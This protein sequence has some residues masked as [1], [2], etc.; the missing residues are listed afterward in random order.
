VPATC[1]YGSGSSAMTWRSFWR[2]CSRIGGHLP[3]EDHLG[4][5]SVI[6]GPPVPSS[7]GAHS[8][9]VGPQHCDN[10]PSRRRPGAATPAPVAATG[11]AVDQSAERSRAIQKTHGGPGPRRPLGRDVD[12]RV[13]GGAARAVTSDLGN[14]EAGHTLQVRARASP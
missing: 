2:A 12:G 7:P 6:S 4:T 14:F 5:H 10:P 1:P 3:G 11:A 9:G 13:V 8:P